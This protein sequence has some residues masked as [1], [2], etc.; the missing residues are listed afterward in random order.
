V[1]MAELLKTGLPAANILRPW[2]HKE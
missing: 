1:D 2:M